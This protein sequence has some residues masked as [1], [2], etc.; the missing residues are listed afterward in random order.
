MSLM[1]SLSDL[2]FLTPIL[3]LFW[4]TTGV[5]WLL[6]DSDTGWHIRDEKGNYCRAHYT[7][8]RSMGLDVPTYGFNGAET[9]SAFEFLKA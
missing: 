1:P 6:T 5:R 7:A 9:S 8:L 3:V 2:A 4:Y